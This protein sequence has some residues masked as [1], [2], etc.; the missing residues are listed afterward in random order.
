MTLAHALALR[1]SDPEAHFKSVLDQLAGD[2]PKIRFGSYSPQIRS[3]LRLWLRTP[4]K[5]RHASCAS[6]AAQRMRPFTRPPKSENV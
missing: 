4:K 6:P 5:S 1:A 3:A 2:P